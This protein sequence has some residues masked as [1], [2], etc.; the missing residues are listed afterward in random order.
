[1]GKLIAK[2]IIIKNRII[3]KSCVRLINLV[4]PNEVS[5]NLSLIGPVWRMEGELGAQ[6][7]FYIDKN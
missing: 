4:I 5:A 3:N 2:L 7:D 1:M 6:M